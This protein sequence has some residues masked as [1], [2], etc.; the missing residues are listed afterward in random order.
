MAP[1]H[2][3][4]KALARSLAT[5]PRR[6]ATYGS[7]RRRVSDGPPIFIV[8]CQRSGTTLMRQILDSHSRI[9]CPGETFF[10]VGLL[11]QIRSEFCRH[12]FERLG[13]S[14]EEVAL[15]ARETILHYF[16]T[17]LH[18]TGKA[19]WADK[20][21]VYAIFGPEIV[22][23]LGQNVR[24]IYMLRH[25]LDV[26]NSMQDRAWMDL[27]APGV[28][29]PLERLKAAARVWIRITESFDAFRM[30]HPELCLTVRFEDFTAH[31]EPTMR[32]VVEFLGEPWEPTML[33]YR[34]FPHSGSGDN[35]TSKHASIRQNSNKFTSWPEEHRR[36]IGELLAPHLERQGY[37][38]DIMTGSAKAERV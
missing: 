1:R 2:A 13:A 18:R 4:L 36:V 16:E 27:I 24:F 37:A 6:A 8:G 29:D 7:S 33:D 12:G 14:R 32:R 9:A 19:R 15:I 25:G 22:E 34:A 20:T 21:P 10:L 31:P 3:P 38:A 26:V 30:T 35:K 23:I 11:D 28:T 17:Y 5:L